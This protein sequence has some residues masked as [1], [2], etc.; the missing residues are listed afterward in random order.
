V[1]IGALGSLLE[2]HPESDL[3]TDLYFDS[4]PIIIMDESDY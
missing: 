1:V 3:S 2:P 4:T